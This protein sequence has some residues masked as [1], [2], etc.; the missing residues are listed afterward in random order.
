MGAAGPKPLQIAAFREVRLRGKIKRGP[1]SNPMPEL[2]AVVEREAP[3]VAEID[4][5]RQGAT[6]LT[7]ASKPLTANDICSD[8]CGGLARLLA[9]RWTRGQALQA[10]W[11]YL[12]D[13]PRRRGADLR[14]AW[15][16]ADGCPHRL[17]AHLKAFRRFHCA[18]GLATRNSSFRRLAQQC[19]EFA[20]ELFDREIR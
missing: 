15:A 19:F 13:H 10:K 2:V 4:T 17:A 5:V 9:R 20:E 8:A 6:R 11:L 12:L 1:A 16:A 18:L 7:S 3:G 14:L